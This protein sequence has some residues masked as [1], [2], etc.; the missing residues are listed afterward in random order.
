MQKIK[1]IIQVAAL[2]SIAI[3]IG[4]NAVADRALANF[5]IVGCGGGDCTQDSACPF[6]S[7]PSASCGC[8]QSFC[9]GGIPCAGSCLGL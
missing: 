7:G 5:T 1:A 4:L 9:N 3:L 6:S 2:A 8:N